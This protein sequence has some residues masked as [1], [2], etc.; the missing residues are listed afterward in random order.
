[1]GRG[2][3]RGGGGVRCDIGRFQV[4]ASVFVA[5]VEG[6]NGREARSGWHVDSLYATFAG[7][8]SNFH[9][10]GEGCGVQLAVCV[11]VDDGGKVK[12]AEVVSAVIT[13]CHSIDGVLRG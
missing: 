6:G 1:M 10:E 8:A 11:G 3:G 9:D 2:D 5:P 12:V 13:V 7:W 4:G